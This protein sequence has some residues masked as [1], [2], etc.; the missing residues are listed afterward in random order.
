MAKKIPKIIGILLVILIG[1]MV[2][3]LISNNEIKLNAEERKWV[4]ENEQTIQNVYL[5]NDTNIFGNLGQGVYYTFLDNLAKEYGIK[6][7]P[8]TIRREEVEENLSFTVGDTLPENALTFYE[9]FYVLVGKLEENITSYSEVKNKKIGVLNS[10]RAYI[11]NYMLSL[12]HI[13]EPTRRSV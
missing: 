3:I 6:M 5:I 10:S 2:F 13:S 11:E 4:S 12:I 8:V 1:V 7:N 9:D